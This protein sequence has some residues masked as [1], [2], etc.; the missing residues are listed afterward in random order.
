MKPEFPVVYRTVV[1]MHYNEINI[2]DTERQFVNIE[3]IF[4]VWIHRHT[5]DTTK[6]Y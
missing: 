1:S 2:I 3:L 4:T 6:Y 5:T